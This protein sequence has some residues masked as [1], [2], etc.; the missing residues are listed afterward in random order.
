M[1]AHGRLAPGNMPGAIAI[2]EKIA[3][4]ESREAA[5]PVLKS[6]LHPLNN[7]KQTQNGANRTNMALAHQIHL[8]LSI[9]HHFGTLENIL[10][11][12]NLTRPA[13]ARSPVGRTFGITDWLAAGRLPAVV[14]MK[15]SRIAE[16]NKMW[17]SG[18]HGIPPNVMLV[19]MG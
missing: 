3:K 10:E 15:L 12:S 14:F 1:H 19:H 8:F 2:K 16:T 9:A 13:A 4:K 17:T 7:R 5:D 11:N 6:T 18:V